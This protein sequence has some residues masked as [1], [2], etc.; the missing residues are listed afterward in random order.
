MNLKIYDRTLSGKIVVTGKDAAMF[1]HN[2]STN[3]VKG[4]AMHHGC[5][6]YFCDRRAKVLGQARIYRGRWKDQD[7]FWLDTI[8]GTAEALFTHLDKHWISEQIESQ[9]LSDQYQQFHVTGLELK[10]LGLMLPAEVLT[11]KPYQVLE[12]LTAS[13]TTQ[14]RRNDLLGEAGY[15]LILPN[16]ESI[17]EFAKPATISPAEEFEHRRIAAGTPFIGQDFLVDRFVMEIN[18]ALNAVSYNKGCYLGQEPIVMSRDRAGHVNRMLMRVKCVEEME[19][20]VSSELKIGEMIVG[21]TT[22]SHSQGLGL[23]YI[24]RGHQDAGTVV[25]AGAVKLVIY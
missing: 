3:D 19:F 12:F 8:P 24:K 21:Q 5:I 20:P 22:K 23:A 13:G 10:N 15:D 16:T 9:D 17:A 2:L 4:L 25:D 18:D 7:A 14:V 6:A 1:L 11:L